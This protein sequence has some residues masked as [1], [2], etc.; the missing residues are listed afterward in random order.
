MEKLTQKDPLPL[1]C[2]GNRFLIEHQL[3]W[4]S[5]QGFKKMDVSL[6]DRSQSTEAL[7][8]TGSRWGTELVCAMDPEHL[9]FPERL[10]KHLARVNGGI[11]LVEGNAVI[12]F[13]F[14][15]E[16]T[17]STLFFNRNQCMPLI[18]CSGEDLATLLA[19]EAVDGIGDLCEWANQ[20]LPDIARVT[21][22]A[23]SQGIYSI[24][25]FLTLNLALQKN[26][27]FFSI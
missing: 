10:R 12:S 14:P 13:D 21:Q 2:V 8:E 1:L 23:F 25:D 19:C 24:E 18:Y 5:D 16:L 11:L 27:S 22:P 6:A 3:E 4:L 20:N 9:S 15:A 26:L 7:V 17:Q